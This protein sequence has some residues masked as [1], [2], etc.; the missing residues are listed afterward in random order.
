ML[1]TISLS[2]LVFFQSLGIGASDIFMLVDLV[3]HAQ[4]H[5]EEYGDDFFIFF[6][7]HYGSLKGEHNQNHQD[8]ES[9]HKN[10][11]FQQNTSVHFLS[12]VDIFTDDFHVQKPSLFT[13]EKDI[14]YYHNIYSSRYS[15]TIFQPPKYA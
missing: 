7:K 8:E 3:E 10:L 15:K 11:P 5:S 9:Q 14:F 13:V 4:Y 1:I 6:E 12:E 2:F